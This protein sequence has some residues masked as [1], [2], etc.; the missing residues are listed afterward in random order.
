MSGFW[1]QLG[2]KITRF[3]LWA[4]ETHPGKLIGTGVG[5]L[6]GFLVV[7][8][9]FWQVVILSLFI[10]V[11]FFLGKRYDEHRDLPA[12]LERFFNR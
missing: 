12:W 7:I 9:G 1:A 2:E 5:L 10:I 11:G 4:L 6:L 3:F 8:I